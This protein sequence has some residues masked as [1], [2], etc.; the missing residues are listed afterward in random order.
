[1]SAVRIT[2]EWGFGKIKGNFAYLDFSK[3]MKPYE[4]DISRLWPVA[5][6]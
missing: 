1:M 5:R 6:F 2:N 3:G 4:Q